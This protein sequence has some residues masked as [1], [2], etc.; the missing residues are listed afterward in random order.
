MWKLGGEVPAFDWSGAEVQ[1]RELSGVKGS[2][3]LVFWVFHLHEHAKPGGGRLILL[4]LLVIQLRPV[5][6]WR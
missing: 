6:S 4:P 1:S 2:T 3:H 5:V